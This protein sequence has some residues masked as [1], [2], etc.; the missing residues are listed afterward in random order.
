MVLLVIALIMR[1][2]YPYLSAFQWHVFIFIR[3]GEV[4]AQNTF[5][6]VWLF[7][8]LVCLYGLRGLLQYML[9]LG[10]AGVRATVL[11]LKSY[12]N[13]IILFFCPIMESLTLTHNHLLVLEL[14]VLEETK[15]I[16]LGIHFFIELPVL[17]TFIP[18]LFFRISLL[19]ITLMLTVF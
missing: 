15:S 13:I 19:A 4:V 3:G 5:Y 8:F 6:V 18:L 16:P 9:H 1:G 7:L 11:S 10:F 14:V 17:L 12:F 2:I